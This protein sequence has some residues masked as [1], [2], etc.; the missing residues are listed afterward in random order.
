MSYVKE[1][2]SY[3]GNAIQGMYIKWEPEGYT[4][5]QGTITAATTK[6]NMT[7]DIRMY[8]TAFN[9]I[10]SDNGDAANY[11]VTAL[12][13]QTATFYMLIRNPL[14]LFEFNAMTTQNKPHNDLIAYDGLVFVPTIT[15]T[16]NAGTLD[17]SLKLGGSNLVKDVRCAVGITK[18]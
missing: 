16:A 18:G 12:S 7:F 15:F 4:A 17:T 6:M 11:G 3:W 10:E 8:A 5:P 2:T 1:F 9:G 14:D 13:G